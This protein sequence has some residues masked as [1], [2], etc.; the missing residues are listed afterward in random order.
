VAALAGQQLPR[1]TLTLPP[2]EQTKSLAHLAE[3]CRWLAQ[4]GATRKSTLVAMGGGVIGDLV[5]FAAATYM[6]GI[7]YIQIPTTL[8]AQVD[9]S[10]GGKVAVDIPEGKNLVGA[11]HQPAAVYIPIDLLQHLP[12]RQF[13][14]GMAEIWKYGFIMD[15]ELTER[16]QKNP[17]PTGNDL[18]EIIEA[19]IRHKAHVVAEDEFET[20]GLRAIL[21]FGHTVGHAIEQALG[22]SSLLHGEAISIGMVAES[23]LGELLGLTPP[24][25]TQIIRSCLEA[26]SLPTRFFAQF[27]PQ[28]MHQDRLAD[29]E[30]LVNAMRRDKKATSGKLAFSLLTSIGGCKLIDG[31]EEQFVYQALQE[32]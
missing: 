8:L 16:L 6:R 7:Q 28:H 3:I 17:Q 15:R 20:K 30:A 19:C 29:P 12:S 21:N 5:G 1:R 14:N 25:T 23:R 27:G 32:I 24:G 18:H 4:N 2:G 13:N 22:Y 9:S 31:V 10:V 26:S 11:F